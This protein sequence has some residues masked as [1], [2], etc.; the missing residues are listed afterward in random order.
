MRTI[1]A[2]LITTLAPTL[3]APAVA[4]DTVTLPRRAVALTGPVNTVFAVGR[5]EGASHEILS[6]IQAAAFDRDNNLYLLDAGN[7][8]VL[9]FDR[10]G[11]F[12]RQIGKQGQGPGEITFATGLAITADGHVVISDAGRTGFSVFTRG[13]EYVRHVTFGE[14]AGLMG[15]G[16]I[17]AS[18]RGGVIARVMPAL[19]P[20]QGGAPPDIPRQAFVRH[21]PLTDGGRFTTLHTFDL[22]QARVESQGSGGNVRMQVMIAPPALAPQVSF[23]VLPDGGIALTNSAEYAVQIIDANGRTTRVIRRDERPRRVTRSDQEGARELRRRQ[24]EG[25]SGGAI[26]VTNVNGQRS[27]SFGGRGM[28]SE[29]IEQ[30]LRTM[31]FADVVPLVQSVQTDPTGRIWIERMP[32]RIGPEPGAIDLVTTAGRYIGTIPRMRRPAAIN[33]DGTLA[34]FIERDDLDVERVVVRSIPATWK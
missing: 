33:H 19:V 21:H 1:T 12:V 4:Q 7:F 20:A 30:Q 24:L 18:P 6:N 14:G 11:R 8:R 15:A 5:E 22:P 31:Q 16:G 27:F 25:G 17:Q 26:S 9:V 34:A 29:Q 32:A 28:T 13:G 23:A 10:Q 2:L 3:A